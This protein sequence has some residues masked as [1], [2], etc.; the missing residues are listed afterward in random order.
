MSTH[1]ILSFIEDRNDIP[2]LSH[3][4]PYLAQCINLRWFEL[5]VS[6]TNV[7]GPTDVRAIEVRLYSLGIRVRR[8]SFPR[9]GSFIAF[10]YFVSKYLHVIT[11]FHTERS[12]SHTYYILTISLF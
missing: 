9:C 12:A 6:R 5:P 11:S 7:Y 3:L 10:L 2:K 8:Y 1:N 4:P